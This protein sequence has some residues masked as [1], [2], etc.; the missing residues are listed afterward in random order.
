MAL[1]HSRFDAVTGE[2]GPDYWEECSVRRDDS[3]ASSA[4]WEAGS[5]HPPALFIPNKRLL[6][7]FNVSSFQ[8]LFSADTAKKSSLT[9]GQKVRDWH[10]R[11]HFPL[12]YDLKSPLP[13]GEG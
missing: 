7:L 2:P 13:L 11:L 10:R 12:G 3:E 8:G 5:H 9:Q 1:S 6:L 4:P